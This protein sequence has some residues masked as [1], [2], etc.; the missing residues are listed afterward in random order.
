MVEVVVV[1]SSGICGGLAASTGARVGWPVGWPGGQVSCG[2]RAADRRGT[3]AKRRAL[4]PRSKKPADLLGVENKKR[5]SVTAR[6]LIFNTS[7]LVGPE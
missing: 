6:P 3:Q 4:G 2:Q 5:P 7:L 1:A